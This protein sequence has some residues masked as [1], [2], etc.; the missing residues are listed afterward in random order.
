MHGLKVM[1]SWLRKIIP[2]KVG[3]S[4]SIGFGLGDMHG[5]V[6]EWCGDYYGKDYYNN[7]PKRDPTGPDEGTHR[8]NRG[9]S[10]FSSSQDCR[11]A[12]RFRLSPEG[13]GSNLGFR[14][15]RSSIK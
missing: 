7:S 4:V 14:V 9:G 15:L 3:R 8:V 1:Q 10:W 13:W 6:W 11:S 5:N 2:M 12:L